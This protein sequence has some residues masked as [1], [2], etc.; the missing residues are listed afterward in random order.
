MLHVLGKTLEAAGMLTVGVAF[1]VYGIGEADMSAELGWL[2]A[3][4]VVFLAG[5]LLV[6]RAEGKQ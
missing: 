5:Y 3:G 4:S 2:M 6:Q 1:F